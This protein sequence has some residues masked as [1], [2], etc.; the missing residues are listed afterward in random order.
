MQP[1]R[2]ALAQL[3]PRLRFFLNEMTKHY[4]DHMTDLEVILESAR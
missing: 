4:A 2:I 1:L 3:A